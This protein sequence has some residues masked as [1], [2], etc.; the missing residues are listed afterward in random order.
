M[1][2]STHYLGLPLAHLF[3][4]GASPLADNLDA[5]KRLEDGGS[6]AIVL[7]SLFEEQITMEM[8]GEIRHRDPRDGQ[9][10]SALAQFPATGHNRFYQPDIDLGR[11]TIAPR[12]E[13]S[14]G[15]AASALAM[16]G[17]AAWTSEG[18]AGNHRRCSEPE[19]RGEGCGGG[20]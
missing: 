1:D 13:L 5:V 2:V 8:R 17:A 11:L 10:G 6:V 18:I 12:L 14:P 19:R 4:V 7:R 16:D 20:G 3:M 15:G 9:F